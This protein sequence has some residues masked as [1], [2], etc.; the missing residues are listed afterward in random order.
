MVSDS[1]AVKAHKSL[2]KISKR[3]K[4]IQFY[5]YLY[6]SKIISINSRLDKENNLQFFIAKTII[7]QQVS[8]GAAKSIWKKV[9]ILLK[10]K[11][12]IITPER[13]V[14]CGLSKPKASYIY[15]VL[16]NVE[17]QLV[18]KKTLKKMQDDELSK[19]FLKIKGIGPWTLGIIKMFYL[20]NLDTYL[21]GDLAIKK[22]ALYFFNDSEYSGE[23]YSPYRTYL[24]LYLWQSISTS[25]D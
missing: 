24:C 4:H 22:R 13:L 17:L 25:L 14:K 20:G 12:I 7:S 6:K 9:E 10:E 3:N 11:K 23:D 15:E 16:N 1:S 5:E 2:L 19:F 8:V 21:N 18:S